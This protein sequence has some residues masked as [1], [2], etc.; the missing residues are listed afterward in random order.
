MY[1]GPYSVDEA[2]KGYADELKECIDY[3]TAGDVAL[4]LVETVQGAGGIQPMPQG[5]MQEAIPHIKKAGG[6]LL[7][8][9]V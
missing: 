3:N 9:E 6:L 5:F 4:F 8:D 7:S 1:R 2:A